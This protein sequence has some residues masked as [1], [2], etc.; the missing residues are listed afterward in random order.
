MKN[1]KK[2]AKKETNSSSS[3]SVRGK[4]SFENNG[5]GK[6]VFIRSKPELVLRKKILTYLVRAGWACTAELQSMRANTNALAISLIASL[7][8]MHKLMSSSSSNTVDL[9]NHVKEAEEEGL[10]GKWLLV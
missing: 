10:F 7:A 3:S 6:T 4:K 2:K 9:E 5:F 1:K 8:R